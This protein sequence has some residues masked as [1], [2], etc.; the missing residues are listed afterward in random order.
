MVQG[1]ELDVEAQC[2]ALVLHRVDGVVCKVAQ[3]AFQRRDLRLDFGSLVHLSGNNLDV[4]RKRENYFVYN[5][6]D[7]CGRREHGA[8]NLAF[9][10]ATDGIEQHVQRLLAAL[11]CGS[12]FAH[13][14]RCLGKALL[15]LFV[16]DGGRYRIE[17]F[18]RQLAEPDLRT[19][20][21]VVVV[22][23][24][25]ACRTEV[26]ESRMDN[27]LLA[28]HVSF[29]F[30]ALFF[31]HVNLK[32]DNLVRG[33]VDDDGDEVV[34]VDV[35]LLV[36]L[37]V[38]TCFFF[39]NFVVVGVFERR[40]NLAAAVFAGLDFFDLDGVRCVGSLVEVPAHGDVLDVLRQVHAVL[41]LGPELEGQR[42]DKRRVD[43][44]RFLGALFGDVEAFLVADEVL[45]VFRELTVERLDSLLVE[46]EVRLVAEQK[47][48]DG[49]GEGLLQLEYAD[50]ERVEL[51][52]DFDLHVGVG[53][54]L[55]RVDV[56]QQLLDVHGGDI[57]VAQ[58]ENLLR[59]RVG[60][61]D[62]ALG[63]EVDDA[64][65][66]VPDKAVEEPPGALVLEGYRGEVLPAQDSD[67]DG[68]VLEPLQEW[69]GLD[70]IPEIVGQRD[71]EIER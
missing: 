47:H 17:Q 32:A 43:V 64:V 42:V 18:L 30:Q 16:G 3:N 29:A 15:H 50:V 5:A 21:V 6:A 59:S 55:L 20:Q 67:E 12:R 1:F 41:V 44:F 23:E 2:S 39:R 38:D 36:V 34:L 11:G 45:L 7:D 62:V 8:R 65:A 27:L 24:G 10:F 31:A 56:G 40:E 63:I 22:R 70:G 71:N 19:Q 46:Q 53:G 69:S 58:L 61:Q 26:F 25:A 54:L 52:L 13:K 9:C 48:V 57:G 60:E 37:D 35:N 49:G 4:R 14:A 66:H 68:A 51:V 33:P 28:Q